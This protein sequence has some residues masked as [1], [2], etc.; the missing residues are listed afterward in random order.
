A[1]IAGEQHQRLPRPHVHP[2]QELDETWRDLALEPVP[3]AQ[4]A[5]DAIER[6]VVVASLAVAVAQVDAF[7]GRPVR[8]RERAVTGHEEAWLGRPGDGGKPDDEQ[9]GRPHRPKA[10]PRRE[11]A[12][13]IPPGEMSIMSSGSV[14]GW[15]Q[16]SA[17][18]SSPQASTPPR[19]THSNTVLTEGRSLPPGEGTPWWGT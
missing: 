14:S 8:D 13:G 19:T 4:D 7:P 12:A 16:S 15:N 6:G 11:T 5:A 2:A 1:A 17:S 9:R 3:R 18:D 10:P